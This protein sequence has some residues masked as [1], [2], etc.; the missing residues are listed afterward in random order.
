MNEKKYKSR[1]SVF[2]TPHKGGR[3]KRIGAFVTSEERK[4]FEKAVKIHGGSQADFIAAA[5]KAKLEKKF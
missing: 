5:S 4:N 3:F 1:A 2:I